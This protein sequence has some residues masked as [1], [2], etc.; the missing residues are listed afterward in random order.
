MAAERG[1]RSNEDSPRR[2]R[3]RFRLF[4]KGVGTCCG[5]IL[6]QLL[7]WLLGIAL[8]ACFGAGAIGLL[9]LIYLYPMPAAAVILFL[10]LV[11]LCLDPTP[12][13]EVYELIKEHWNQIG[14]A[15]TE[16]I[17]DERQDS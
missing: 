12:I 6:L 11:A 15:I 13:Y 14:S 1:E 5:E 9:Y 17:R 8:Y 2:R 16:I 4:N 3:P 7:A 10:F